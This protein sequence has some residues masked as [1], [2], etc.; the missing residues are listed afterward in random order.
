MA[1]YYTDPNTGQRVKIEKSHKFRNFVVFPALGFIVLIIIVAAVSGGG[2]GPAGNGPGTPAEAGT[3]GH[4]VRYEVTG[5]GQG[6]ITFTTDANMSMSQ[7]TETLPWSTEVQFGDE[8]FVPLSVNVT[9]S[10]QG[11]SGPMGCKIIVDGEVVTENHS[12]GGQAATVSCNG[13]M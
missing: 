5:E 12:T 13:S 10:F 8:V 3:T 6:M 1:S 4:T 2:S 11:G 7:A 9:R